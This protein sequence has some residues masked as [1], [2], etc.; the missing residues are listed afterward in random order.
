MLARDG[1]MWV[2]RDRVAGA[3][4]A[5]EAGAQAIV[6][7]DG[8][9]NPTLEKALSLVVVDGETRKDEWPFGDGAVFPAGPMREPLAAGLKRADAVVL[10]L[11]TD[12]EAADPELR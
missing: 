4:A 10:L 2:S 8:H 9:Q 12:I 7:D 3:L 6:L 5:V 11:P 1:A